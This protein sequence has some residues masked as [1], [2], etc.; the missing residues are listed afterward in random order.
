MGPQTQREAVYSAVQAI[1]KKANIK[2]EDG[3]KISEA[4]GFGSEQ[5][6]EVIAHVVS[7]FQDGKTRI[8]KEY[9]EQE[10]KSY[11]N[12]LV[13]NWLRKDTRLNGGSKYEI[14]N[15][16]SRA[17]QGNPA[18][19]ETKKLLKQVAGTDKEPKVQAVLDKMVAEHKASNT[20]TAKIDA[21][22]LP[23]E[24]RNLA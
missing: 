24:L 3:M 8:T 17:G 9:S 11:C 16:G 7:S 14:Q 23:E 21:S 22:L 10:L 2:F 1:C 18:I 13:S 6:K 5:R 15:P 12:G 19:K 20:K 4:S